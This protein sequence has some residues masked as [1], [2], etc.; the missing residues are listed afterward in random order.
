MGTFTYANSDVYE[1]QWKNGYRDGKGVLKFINGDEYDGEW[2]DN[3]PSG[4]G[5]YKTVSGYTYRGGW[6]SGKVRSRECR[7]FLVLARPAVR[8]CC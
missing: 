5:T 1:G 4:E 8:R 2:K 3:V 7:K 6:D